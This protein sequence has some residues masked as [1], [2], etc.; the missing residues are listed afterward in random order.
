MN[1][2]PYLALAGL[3]VVLASAAVGLNHIKHATGSAPEHPATAQAQ[4]VEAA[5]PAAAVPS[6]PVSN[7]WADG[8][9]ASNVEFLT[10]DGKLTVLM[11]NPDTNVICDKCEAPGGTLV[12]DLKSDAAADGSSQRETYTFDGAYVTSTTTTIDG[13]DEESAP[14]PKVLH[15]E[16]VEAFTQLEDSMVRAKTKA[17]ADNV[18]PGPNQNVPAEV[19]EKTKAATP[20]PVWLTKNPAAPRP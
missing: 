8:Q 5:K 12:V 18:G 3:A 16:L 17:I 11:D 4:T 13:N 10:P 20:P 9:L 14:T 6:L 1:K 15:P 2:R 7:G 19:M